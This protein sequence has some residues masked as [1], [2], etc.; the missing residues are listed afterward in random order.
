MGFWNCP[1]RAHA[2]RKTVTVVWEDGVARCTV[3]TCEMT[4][5]E[6]ERLLATAREV[7]AEERA[8]RQ[9]AFILE[10]VFP[11][12]GTEIL[13]VF[14]TPEAAMLTRPGLWTSVTNEH[15]THWTTQK[16]DDAQPY[17]VVTRYEI[18]EK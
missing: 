10:D 16:N 7:I 15:G 12:D 8:K 18:R 14:T 11:Y 2:E 13:G 17:R 1:I 5:V 9:A 6:T 3:P 4:S